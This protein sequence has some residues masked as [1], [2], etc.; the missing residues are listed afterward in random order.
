ME[1][2]LIKDFSY[3]SAGYYTKM[4]AL[5]SPSHFKKCK[6]KKEKSFNIASEHHGDELMKISFA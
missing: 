1:K 2:T 4:W 5:E 6:F 3:I